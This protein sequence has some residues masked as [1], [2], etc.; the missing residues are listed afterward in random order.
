MS[1]A[2]A[3]AVRLDQIRRFGGISG[4]EVAHL[5]NTTPETVSRWRTGK[6]EPQPDRRDSLLRLEWLV[7]ELAE[8]YSPEEARLWLFSPHKRLSG[9]RP[10]DL[11]TR[12]QT[13]DVLRIIAQLKDGA[14]V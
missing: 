11:I 1:A 8:L 4:R 3:I 14:Y 6:T 12:G 10:V 7:T 9:E 13:E 2:T 5:L